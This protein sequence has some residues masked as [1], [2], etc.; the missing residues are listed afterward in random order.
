MIE[1]PRA[2]IL[3]WLRQVMV[4]P[5]LPDRIV[6]RH[7]TIDER[8]NEISAVGLQGFVPN[9]PALGTL[10]DDVAT[11]IVNDASGFGGIQKYLVIACLGEALL[12]RLPVRQTTSE[13]RIGD[14]VDSEPPTPHGLL[15]QLMRHNEAQARLFASAMG[16]I[17]STMGNTIER[18]K[19][20]IDR[21]DAIRIEALQ[22]IEDL[23]SQKHA[24]KIETLREA[25]RAKRFESLFGLA[26]GLAPVVA[27]RVLGKKIFG[28]AA[29][30]PTRTLIK[31][32]AESLTDDQKL[33]MLGV[34]DP[35]QVVALQE[36]FA[37]VSGQEAAGAG[38]DATQT[39]PQPASGEAAA[40]PSSEDTT[41]GKS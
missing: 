30:G 29:A 21:A 6:V 24:R 19:A 35:T 22:R 20:D 3:D 10:A 9:E 26:M 16:Q 32:F 17:V 39:A 12:A 27:D 25:S 11:T 36:L 1:S 8:Q 14:A 7:I 13:V 23:I 4:G 40:E 5:E 18:Q 33:K 31:R 38:G 28:G 34:L 41:G 15:S 37:S 2:R